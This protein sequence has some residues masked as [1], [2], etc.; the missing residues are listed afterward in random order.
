MKK[1][2]K[3]DLSLDG[4]NGAHALSQGLIQV[5][6]KV[7]SKEKQKENNKKLFELAKFN[8]IKHKNL[9]KFKQKEFNREGDLASRI[10]YD[11]IQAREP[12]RPPYKN[13][14]EEIRVEVPEIKEYGSLS[15]SQKIKRRIHVKQVLKAINPKKQINMDA[16]E[17]GSEKLKEKQK[18]ISLLYRRGNIKTKY[19]KGAVQKGDA[20]LV[21]LVSSQLTFLDC[22]KDN[23]V[24]I[25][26]QKKTIN[27]S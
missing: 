18:R 22:L 8:S 10:L 15:H 21:E 16:I 7:L 26:S 6:R 20:E 3:G 17:I 5:N 13:Y 1:R 4:K 25:P 2:R 23:I 11:E 27:K 12:K 14:L 24:R 19:G 9:D